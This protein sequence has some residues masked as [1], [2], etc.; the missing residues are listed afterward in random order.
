MKV[1]VVGGDGVI[2]GHLV[3]RL[4]AAGWHVYSTTRRRG[5]VSGRRIFL[6]LATAPR[7]WPELDTFDAIVMCA[8]VVGFETCRRDPVA[9]A[10]VNVDA[11]HNVARRYRS[12]GTS[13]MLL[14]STA[15]FDGRRPRVPA[16][17]PPCPRTEYGR[18]KARAESL[19]LDNLPGSAVIRLTKVVGP[20]LPSYRRWV[21]N[22]LA[23]KEVSAFCDVR[24][25]PVPVDLAAETIYRILAQEGHGIYQLSGDEDLSQ[26]ETARIL[27]AAIGADPNLVVA[28][29]LRRPGVK[30]E[31][32]YPHTTLDASRIAREFGLDIPSSRSTVAA[33]ARRIADAMTGAFAASRR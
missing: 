11:V 21:E 14:S 6:D 20:E 31:D 23:R 7:H 28:T 2:G 24:R 33:T 16:E 10:R 22:L 4:E 27:A 8:A 26:T 15:V 19:V 13:F 18:Q 9:S 12:P 1:L 32:M 29:R 5:T 25:A 3:T 17:A 30:I